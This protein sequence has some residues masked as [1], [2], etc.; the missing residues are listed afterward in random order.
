M[1]YD[2][3]GKRISKTILR[4]ISDGEWNLTYVTHYTGIGTEIREYKPWNFTRF[5][6]S[7]GIEH[8]ISANPDYAGTASTDCP[9]PDT[10]KVVVPLPSGLGRYALQNVAY[11]ESPLQGAYEFYLKDHLG[12]TRVVY[13]IG[14]PDPLDI[15]PNGVFRAAYDY[16]SFGEQLDLFVF[17]RKVTENFTGKEKDDETQLDYFGARYL[18]LMLGLWVSV[19]PKRQ[20]ASPYL[21]AGNGVNPVNGVDENGNILIMDKNTS[22]NYMSWLNS[23][24]PEINA[25]RWKRFNTLNNSPRI[26]Q[27]IYREEVD[28]DFTIGGI[29]SKGE[30]NPKTKN[31]YVNGTMENFFHEI[32]GHAYQDEMFMQKQGRNL[33]GRYRDCG[34]R[35][36]Q[37]IPAHDYVRQRKG[38]CRARKDSEG[39]GSRV[40]FRKALPL[41]GTRSEREHELSDTAVPAERN[42]LWEPDQGTGEADRVETEQQAE[43]E[44]WISDTARVYFYTS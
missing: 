31:G 7:Q 34:V 29:H 22:Q 11:E 24:T 25:E 41:V 20:F 3:N 39:T 9:L 18:D 40:L 43:K 42:V 33:S 6:D 26:Y 13:G 28:Y 14:F 21:Y 37:G 16:R 8:C 4:K 27:S 15:S 30:Y 1:S 19:D 23:S 12:S 35:A 5:T 44:T 10:V 38:V 17:T 2:G 36:L 32:L